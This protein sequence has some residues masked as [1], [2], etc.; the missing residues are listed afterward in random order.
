MIKTLKIA[1]IAV[2][3]ASAV[4]LAAVG[5]FALKGDPEMEAYL[6]KPGAIEDYK[7]K[8][9]GIDQENTEA[10]SPL[11]TQARAFSLRIDPPPPPA[12][13]Q[14][15]RPEL[16]KEITDLL[17]DRP[18]VPKGPI[19]VKFSLVA[20]CKYEDRPE[21]SLALLDMP[22][23]GQKWFRQGDTV[24]H[25]VLEAV[26]DGMIVF[27]ANDRKEEVYMPRPVSQ[28]PLLK[29]DMPTTT[30]GLSTMTEDGKYINPA[31]GATYSPDDPKTFTAGTKDRYETYRRTQTADTGAGARPTPGTRPAPPQTTVIVS[32][33]EQTKQIDQSISQINKLIEASKNA[34]SAEEAAGT[35]ALAAI[36]EKLQEGK[37][38]LQNMQEQ[39]TER[40]DEDPKRAQ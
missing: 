36:L 7:E 24:G 27:N 20:T 40:S 19:T 23:E 14:S 16:P 9:A 5:F 26:G 33:E 32:P 25:G 15:E 2:L 10:E 11:V 22:G 3:I 34:E 21:K 8:M 37:D 13:K 39:M 30:S 1:C 4:T 28:N 31:T 38:E 6:A 29:S 12:P 35:A 17:N 18:S